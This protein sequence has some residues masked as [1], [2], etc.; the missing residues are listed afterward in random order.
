MKQAK[1]DEAFSHPSLTIIHS[2]SIIQVE[3]KA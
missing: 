3:S 1:I 2:F